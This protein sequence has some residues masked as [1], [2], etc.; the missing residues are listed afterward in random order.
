[1]NKNDLKIKVEA[2]L[3]RIK[4]MANIEKAL[5]NI[6]TQLS[7]IKIRGTLNS[8]QTKKELNTR[9]KSIRPKIKV[10]A[11]T[12]QAA[13]KVKKLGQQNNQ[14]TIKPTIDDSQVTAGLK[15]TQEKTKS[16][17]A[18]I[19]DGVT[20]SLIR[21]SVQQVTQA[22][23]EA[24]STVKE[25]DSIKTGI[26]SAS[27]VSDT[28]ADTM[29]HSYNQTAQN[30]GSTTKNIGNA[31]NEILRM[32]LSV[33]DTDRLIETSTILA[34]NGMIDTS[35]AAEYLISTMNGYQLTAGETMKIIDRLTGVD[36]E[37]PV[38][39]GGL[40]EAVSKC[41]DTAN[42]SG[43]S[44]ERLIGY[45]AAIGETTQDS[46]SA[47][48]TSLKSVYDRMS[49]IKAGKLADDASGESL[50]NTE[51]Y[52][53][54]LGIQL[55]DT[56][57]SYRDFDA[58]LD[59][60]NTQ[61]QNMT[62]AEQQELAAAMAGNAQKEH[63]ADLMNNYADA[64][65]YSETAAGSAGSALERYG[66]YQNSLDARVNV[67]TASLESLFTDT[68]SEEL[69][70][71]IVQATTGIVQF[72]EGAQ[73]LKGTFA[74]LA[75]LGIS[76]IFVSMGAGMI[77]AYK[78]T[79]PLINAMALLKKEK[80][81]ENLTAIGNACKGLSDKQLK[82]VLSAKGLQHQDRLTILSGKGV[83]DE[84]K[85][86]TLAALGFSNAQDKAAG[87]SFSLRGAFNALKTA[88]ATNPIGLLVTAV[89]SAVMIFTNCN[90]AIEE[91]REKA[92][93][94][95]GSFKETS[96]DIENYK[97]KIAD[98]HNTINDSNSSIEDVTDAR[99][100][101]MGVQDELIEKFGTEKDAIN[102][103]TDA[104]NGQTGALDMLTQKEWQA[105]KNEFNDNG[106]WKGFAN[107]FSGYSSNIDRMLDEYEDYHARIRLNDFINIDN[108]GQTDTF[109]SLLKNKFDAEITFD[110]SEGSE[111]AML[112]GNA[113]EIYEKLL[114]IQNLSDQFHFSDA[115]ENNLTKLANSAR[116]M[117]EQY[118]DF[119]NQYILQDKI[120]TNGSDY[121]DSF[122]NITN[123]YDEYSDALNSG[124]K[125]KIA[126][127]SEKYA[128]TLTEAMDSAMANGDTDVASYFENMYPAMQSIVS[129]WKFD[130]AFNDNTND[131]QTIVQSALDALKD[132]SGRS[133][134][135][136]EI[137]GLDEENT[138]YQVL[139]EAANS[140]NMSI[141][142]MIALLKERN[143]VSAMDYQGL[144]GLFGQE[145]VDK[146]S[147][148][149]LEIAY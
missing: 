28:E 34:K 138:Q 142:E 2:V 130:I 100:T 93:E 135:A 40:A 84:M 32:G 30:L 18:K 63:F 94:L 140:Y 58:V 105:V 79:M 6:E 96:S 14:P 126:E 103:I 69:Y 107:F 131:L 145:N 136:E 59:D 64:L 111:I 101:L 20:S 29:M 33:S 132:E 19:K 92:Q 78:N 106:F 124:D 73:A 15:T 115:F 128:S 117:S 60:I 102:S 99:K 104:I 95:G 86:E 11:D 49:N 89:S 25:L 80:S 44:L 122:K 82:L 98:L 74:G 121:S 13:E 137:L 12:K 48:G 143:L 45:A 116:N 1:M 68:V 51:L 57:N 149:E 88:I 55:R 10:D 52:L 23:H 147:P 139:Q 8:T 53:N 56:S 91:I 87:A 42:D 3:D 72:L 46:M 120:L 35:Q 77:T 123:A 7:K 38:S 16:F 129:G 141:E 90:Q 26:Q 83:E 21:M 97:T 41:A 125:S 24:V 9:L 71:G 27:G 67:L 85:E 62:Q 146:L 50:A 75:A 76:K 148:E 4:S 66:V 110:A 61:W 37:A 43:T 144:V 119:Y 108:L 5:K 17:F 36:K 127:A 70:G 39:A 65:K 134:T 31:A 118:K 81:E 22:I 113:T 54:K 112:S 47:V 114:E 133:L 109:K